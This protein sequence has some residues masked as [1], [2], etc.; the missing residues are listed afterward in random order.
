[1]KLILV[2]GLA[3]LMLAG[4]TACSDPKHDAKDTNVQEQMENGTL[5]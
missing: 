1:M 3:V 4:L 2:I 5:K